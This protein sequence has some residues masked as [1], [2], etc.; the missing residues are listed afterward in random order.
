VEIPTAAGLL[1]TEKDKC[2][3]CGLHSSNTI[4]NCAKAR[5]MGLDEKRKV[6]KDKRCCHVCLR[7]NHFARDCKSYVKCLLCSKKHQSIMCP[8]LKVFVESKTETIVMKPEEKIQSTI[9]NLSCSSKVI[10]K[11]IMVKISG[12]SGSKVVR[13]LIDDGS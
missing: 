7:P 11:T 12:P 6:I 3:F 5:V 13:V 9:S 8:D 2:I 1:V 10:L 4:N